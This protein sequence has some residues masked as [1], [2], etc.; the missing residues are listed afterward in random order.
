MLSPQLRAA[1]G[2]LGDLPPADLRQSWH[3]AARLESS[4]S[5]G[6]HLSV[7]H[8]LR[9]HVS[10]LPVNHSPCVSTEQQCTQQSLLRHTG[11]FCALWLQRCSSCVSFAGCS[12]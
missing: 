4:A 2:H 8:L 6:S 11:G 3:A 1:A 5:H 9:T 10:T 7:R 12:P